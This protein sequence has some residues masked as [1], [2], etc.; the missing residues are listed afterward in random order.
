MVAVTSVPSSLPFDSYERGKSA[1]YPTFIINVIGIAGETPPQKHYKKLI[2]MKY[3]LSSLLATFLY[4]E[5]I[6]KAFCKKIE[7]SLGKM[8]MGKILRHYTMTF[9]FFCSD[10]CYSRSIVVQ[11]GDRN[12]VGTCSFPPR[13]MYRIG[14]RRATPP[15]PPP[16]RDKIKI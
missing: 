7:T 5:I 6:F 9:F 4:F 14:Y 2:D 1:S 13:V 3:V 12:V 10:K 11:S 15:P 8:H 16:P